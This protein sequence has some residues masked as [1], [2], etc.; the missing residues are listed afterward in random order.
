MA[1][2]M[3]RIGQ[4][5]AA[6][7]G[8]LGVLPDF[9]DDADTKQVQQTLNALGGE[10]RLLGGAS[11]PPNTAVGFAPSAEA[12]G[13]AGDLERRIMNCAEI[14]PPLFLSSSDGAALHESFRR[15]VNTT[16]EHLCRLVSEG[17]SR[18]QSCQ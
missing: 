8:Q 1:S 15:L 11:G 18:N 3:H 12:R 17:A 6:P 5:A 4:Q 13:W 2:L 7:A 14:S 9:P 16:I 10:L